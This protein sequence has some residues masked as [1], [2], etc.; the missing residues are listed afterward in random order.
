MATDER[1]AGAQVR[2]AGVWVLCCLMTPGLSKNIQHHAW[3]FSAL[4]LQITISDIRSQVKR[5]VSLVIAN[6]QFDLPCQPCNCRCPL[7]SSSGVC[8]VMHR[9]MYSLYCCWGM[10]EVDLM[11]ANDKD[12]TTISHAHNVKSQPYWNLVW[13]DY[14]TNTGNRET[15]M[16]G[17]D[18]QTVTSCLHSHCQ[19]IWRKHM[20]KLI[21]SQCMFHTVKSPTGSDAFKAGMFKIKFT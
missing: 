19:N 3:P 5:A 18:S 7:W 11:K 13:C 10:Q 16:D 9:I 2:H 8:V 20:G 4:C 17:E 1:F 15:M 12:M 21:L 14:F 6:G